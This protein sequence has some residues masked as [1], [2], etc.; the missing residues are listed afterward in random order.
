MVCTIHYECHAR[1]YLTELSD[2]QPVADEIIMMQYMLLKVS[3]A[4]IRE[5]TDYYVRILYGRLYVCDGIAAPYG[6]NRVRIWLHDLLFIV[7]FYLVN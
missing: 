4:E 3:I 2:N 1:C 6:K 7:T 5:V